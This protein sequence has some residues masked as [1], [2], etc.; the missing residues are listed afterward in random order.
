MKMSFLNYGMDMAPISNDT[1]GD[2]YQYT[3]DAVGNRLTETTQSSVNSY[4]YDVANRMTD[5]NGVPYTWDSNGNLLND[6]VNAYTYDSAN[7]LT[8]F[9]GGQTAT[10]AYNGLGDR[11]S[12]N[13]VNYTLDLNSGLT[14][15]LN[16]GTNTYAYG[17][18]RIS[19]TNT[20]TEYFLGDA[21]GSVRQIA[22]SAGEITLAKSYEPYG[23][24]SQSSGTAQTIYGFTG[25]STD[26]NGL[27]YLRARY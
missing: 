20:A 3:Y 15:V 8:S 10:Y 16:D 17:L 14:Q 5:V 26:A 12:Q 21:L 1:T 22:N 11:L 9:S 13:G 18:G 6:G 27:V 25:E 23:N 2:S 7:R 4:Q 24:V 19:Q